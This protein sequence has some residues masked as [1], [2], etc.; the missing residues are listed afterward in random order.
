MGFQQRKVRGGRVRPG[1]EARPSAVG[2]GRYAMICRARSGT[3]IASCWPAVR[4]MP[5]CSGITLP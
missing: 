2:A 5:G 4:F 3:S 1:Q